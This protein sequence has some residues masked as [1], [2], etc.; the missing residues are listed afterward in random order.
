MKVGDLVEWTED[1]DIGVVTLIHGLHA[2][3]QWKDEPEKSSLMRQD[4][5]R[6][7]KLTCK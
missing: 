2:Y 1:G 4:N 7:R 6:L 3:I 5:P